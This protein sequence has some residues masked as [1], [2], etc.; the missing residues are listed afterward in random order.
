MDK[1]RAAKKT[2]G[3]RWSPD[4]IRFLR[5]AAA[6]SGYYAEIARYSGEAAEALLRLLAFPAGSIPER[7]ECRA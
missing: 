1:E 2:M 4:T 5:D 6:V 7:R 3:Q